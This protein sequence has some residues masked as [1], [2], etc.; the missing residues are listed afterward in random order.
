MGIRLSQ[1][2]I[3]IFVLPLI[4]QAQDM[5]SRILMYVGNNSTEAGEF[6]RMYKKSLEPDNTLQVDDYLK[7]FTLFKLKV[8]DAISEGYDTTKAFR[9]ELNGYRSQLAQN[10]LTDSQTKENLL[11]KAYQRSLTEIN[12]WHIL[13]ALPQD[14]LPVDTLKAWK[15]RTR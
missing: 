2:L 11:R 13:I 10:Y 7:Q 12:A 15:K 4:C 8:A 5:N 6:L 9:S 1:L 3:S 14:A